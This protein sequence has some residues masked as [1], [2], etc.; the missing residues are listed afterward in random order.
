MGQ[1]SIDHKVA[2]GYMKLFFGLVPFLL[3]CCASVQAGETSLSGAVFKRSIQK[4]GQVKATTSSKARRSL[5]LKPALI[6]PALIPLHRVKPGAL[7]KAEG[8]TIT[9]SLDLDNSIDDSALLEDLSQAC[10]WNPNMIFQ[11]KAAGHVFY[12]LPREFMLVRDEQGYRLSVQYNTQAEPG[13]PS[14][15]LTAELKAPHRTGDVKLLKAILREAMG[16][17]SSDPLEIKSLQGIGATAD[18]EALATGLAL[19]SDRI[20]LSAPADFKQSFRLTLSLT[21]EEV[22]EV[23]AQISREG[24]AGTLQV[25]VGED[26]VPVPIRI[27]YADFTGNRVNGFD[28][29]FKKKP[30][31]KIEN[32]TDFP[33]QLHSINGYRMKGGHLERVEKQ[34]KQTRAIPAK[35][36]RPFKLP[37]LHKVLGN[38]VVLAWLGTALDSECIS[39]LQK[40]DQQVRKGVALAQGS[41]IKF[42][43]IP[44]VFS[45]FG[46]YKIVVRVR[47]PFFVSGGKTVE[48]EEAELTADANQNQAL[49]LF[50]PSGR[51]RNALM[52]RYQVQVVMESGEVMQEDLWHDAS[53]LS[54][55]FGSAQLES[56]LA[57]AG[58]ESSE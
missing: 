18:M 45:E 14:V 16:L 36:S 51:G 11:D 28:Q 42:E 19:S 31:G 57:E 17:K 10:G 32:V 48:E 21:Q 22:E 24:L 3:L 35:G 53:Q 46:I 29:W 38:D 6:K 26:T 27:R 8:P 54:Q 40:I 30:I 23:L 58:E 34:L 39:C 1:A 15:M 47:S 12:Y 52:Y 5:N 4:S 33:L 55:F 7:K 20:H 50:I 13:Q 41:P 56:F 43:A 49:T 44:A 37:P 25:K 9:A 2:G